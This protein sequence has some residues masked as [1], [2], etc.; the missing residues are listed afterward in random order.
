M[1]FSDAKW[2]WV[3]NA[4]KP[5][6]TSSNVDSTAKGCGS[7]IFGGELSI[8]LLLSGALLMAKRNKE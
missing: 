2:I 7:I 3:E 8:L 4:S 1:Q 5:D 6:S